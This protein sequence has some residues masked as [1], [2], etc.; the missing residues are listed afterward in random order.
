MH[1]FFAKVHRGNDVHETVRSCRRDGL[2]DVQARELNTAD[3]A[4]VLPSAPPPAWL[5]LRAAY[6]AVRHTLQSPSTKHAYS[7]GRQIPTII[8]YASLHPGV[9]SSC[10]A[11]RR[12]LGGVLLVA[13]D[14]V[15]NRV[16]KK[17]D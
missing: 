10:N 11:G 13:Q 15:A 4:S 3:L 5:L 2:V 1:C 8:P 7:A 9:A 16:E 6:N 12:M 14:G 17:E